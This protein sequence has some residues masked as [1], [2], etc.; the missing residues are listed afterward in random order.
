MVVVMAEEAPHTGIGIAHILKVDGTVGVA[1][2]EIL[3]FAIEIAPFLGEADD[4]GG[5]D[6]FNLWVVDFL[7]ALAAD[8]VFGTLLQGKL[9]DAAQVG[10]GG[11]Q[12]PCR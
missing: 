6:A 11:G 5:I 4:I 8:A 9:T 7:E 2:R 12:D 10:V 1:E 3:V